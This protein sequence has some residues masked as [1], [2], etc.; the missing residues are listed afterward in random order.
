MF[1]Y[2]DC[3]KLSS[4]FILKAFLSHYTSQLEK[5]T[6]AKIVISKCESLLLSFL[7]SF[8]FSFFSKSVNFFFRFFKITFPCLI[9]E[10]SDF[11]R[12]DSAKFLFCQIA[13]SSMTM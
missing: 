9:I 3:K 10:L 11:Q 4:Y 1:R 12:Y 8:R 13:L 2:R 7:S 5:V 6:A